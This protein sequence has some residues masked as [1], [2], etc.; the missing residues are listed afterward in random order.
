MKIPFNQHSNFLI[1]VQF[2]AGFTPDTLDGK[3]EL[4]LSFLD[5]LGNLAKKNGRKLYA[6]YSIAKGSIGV[7]AHFAVS[8]LP[9]SSGYL[10]TAQN[11]NKRIS[12]Y[13]V[14]SLLEQSFFYVDNPTEAIKRISHNKKYVTNYVIYQPRDGQVSIF[15][16]IYIY[17]DFVPVYSELKLEFY[18]SKRQFGEKEKMNK[19][20]DFHKIIAIMVILS[21]SLFV[22]RKLLLALL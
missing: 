15:S 10:K 13:Q 20:R 12:R 17:H 7:H 4:C 8:W 14:I 3:N 6:T 11:G 19:N 22:I 21:T 2:D 9:L 5:S 18:C 1:S 16:D